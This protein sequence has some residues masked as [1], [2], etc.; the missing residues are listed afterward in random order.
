MHMER[1]PTMCIVAMITGFSHEKLWSLGGTY[2]L[3]TPCVCDNIVHINSKLLDKLLDPER[4]P[5]PSQG[6][7]DV[8][9][10]NLVPLDNPYKATTYR[11]II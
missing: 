5:N 2:E 8:M 10:L 9:K 11:D 1:M 7:I 6:L 4:T 3:L